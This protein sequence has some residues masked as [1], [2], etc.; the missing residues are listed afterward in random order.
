VTRLS[1]IFL[2][3]WNMYFKLH[4]GLVSASVISRSA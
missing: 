3:G 4:F 1:L 2:L